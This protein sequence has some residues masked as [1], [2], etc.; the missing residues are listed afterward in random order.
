MNFS[1]STILYTLRLFSEINF[2]NVTIV[3]ATSNGPKII[4]LDQNPQSIFSSESGI[5]LAINYFSMNC[6]N[7][8]SFIDSLSLIHTLRARDLSKESLIISLTNG[9]F[10]HDQQN[11]CKKLEFSFHLLSS[12]LITIGIGYYPKTI[13]KIFSNCI[14]SEDPT[15]LSNVFFNFFE[16]KFSSNN[17]INPILFPPLNKELIK[18]LVDS[19]SKYEISNKELEKELNSIQRLEDTYSNV[20]N[21]LIQKE[22]MKNI[23][24]EKVSNLGISGKWNISVLICQF[25]DYKMSIIKGESEHITKETLES[26]GGLV[27][28]LEDLGMKVIISQNY[29]DSINYLSSG[30]FS[31]VWI[32]C[33]RGEDK[34]PDGNPYYNLINQF[35]N[36]VLEFRKNGGGVSF[37]S[38]NPP[39]TFEAN[40][41]LEKLELE[42]KKIKFKFINEEFGSKIL[43]YGQL[44]QNYPQSQIYDQSETNITTKYNQEYKINKQHQ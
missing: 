42:N 19:F 15:N 16:N 5:L 12:I 14:W 44:N 30:R 2:Q 13:S 29:Y 23:N 17:L 43:K 33:G 3:A 1:Y 10:T 26:P 31:Q 24:Q 22:S 35:I 40:K 39:L 4:C 34:L 41:F 7:N 8:S 28:C 32:I 9:L 21:P 36:C 25:Y 27:E 6:S 18:N 37:W 11:Q 38:D 20:F